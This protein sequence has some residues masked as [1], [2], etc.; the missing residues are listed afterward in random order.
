MITILF[1]VIG[2]N[3]NKQIQL[4]Q[5][6]DKK[7]EIFFIDYGDTQQCSIYLRKKNKVKESISLVYKNENVLFCWRETDR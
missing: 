6:E 2:C 5:L 4:T 7:V 3:T 1:I